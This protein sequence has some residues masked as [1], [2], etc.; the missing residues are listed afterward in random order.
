L[1]LIRRFSYTHSFISP[2]WQP[3]T[4]NTE[5]KR[6]V[7]RFVQQTDL[8]FAWLFS[9]IMVCNNFNHLYSPVHGRCA[10]K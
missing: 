1:W 10:K 9:V 3:N 6:T 4:K 2:N 8:S 7:L 5:N